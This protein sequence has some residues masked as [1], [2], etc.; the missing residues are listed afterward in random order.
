M[1]AVWVS[2]N[3]PAAET[4]N[5]A[6]ARFRRAPATADVAAVNK[7]AAGALPSCA[8]GIDSPFPFSKGSAR[9]SLVLTQN[10]KAL[11]NMFSEGLFRA[12]G[13]RDYQFLR[14]FSQRRK[15]LVLP[16]RSRKKIWVRTR[17][18]T[19]GPFFGDGRTLLICLS[20]LF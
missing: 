8:V 11:P 16:P 19:A 4:R 15:T 20:Q 12:V 10:S 3:G 6:A 14:C 7:P 17:L 5:Q 1:R 13:Y 2:C 9:N 18:A